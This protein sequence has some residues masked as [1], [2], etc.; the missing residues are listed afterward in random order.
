MLLK[1]DIEFTLNGVTKRLTVDVT[2]TAALL[3]PDLPVIVHTGNVDAMP[4]LAAAGADLRR[5]RRLPFQAPGRSRRHAPP[6][7]RPGR[8]AAVHVFV[9]AVSPDVWISDPL[10]RCE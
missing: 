4:A 9:D 8:H 5:H 3:R 10:T 2:M 1:H 6:R 7:R